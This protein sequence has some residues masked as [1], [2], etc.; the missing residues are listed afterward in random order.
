MQFSFDE[1]LVA[2]EVHQTVSAP[3]HQQNLLLTL[4]FRAICLADRR[5]NSV[6]G[7]RSTDEAFGTGPKHGSLIT[8]DLM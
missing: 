8:F 5:S 6:A 2:G 4:F 1:R 3:V 7:F